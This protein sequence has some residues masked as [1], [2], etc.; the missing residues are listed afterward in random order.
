MFICTMTALPKLFASLAGLPIEILLEIYQHLDLQ[1]IFEL[2]L[3]NSEF[4]LFF[5]RRKIDIL[6]PVLRRDFDPLDELLQVYT[7]SADDIVSGGLYKPRRVVFQ[8]FAGDRGVVLSPGA[9][10][11]GLTGLL[12]GDK[13]TEVTSG[14]KALKISESLSNAVVLTGLDLN[15]LLK[16]CRLVREWEELFPQ[17]RWYHQPE[18]CRL[19]RCHEQVRLR[20]ALYRWWLYGIYFHGD[21]P[22][23]RAAHPEPFVDDIRTSQMR[24][25]STAELLEL[26]DFLETIKDVILQYICPRLDPNQQQVCSCPCPR[27]GQFLLTQISRLLHKHLWSKTLAG[28]SPFLQV[29][30]TKVT[31]VVLSRH[32]Q[33]SGQRNSCI[34]SKTSTAIRESA[35]SQI[36]RF[37]TRASP[38]TRSPFRWPF[39]VP[40]MKGAG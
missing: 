35:S 37:D 21:F 31:G 34:T 8:R 18:D 15:G 27:Q 30:T 38:W 10:F 23:P 2:S 6:L 3:T 22:R 14:R 5:Q 40:W 29:G 33:N 39:V 13:F 7:A 11:P 20:K 26:M 4:F 32:T 9:H 25:H 19:L 1:S 24:Y 36:F 28:V 16:K 12:A 17:M